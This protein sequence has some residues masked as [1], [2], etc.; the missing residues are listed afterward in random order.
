[1][2]TCGPPVIDM[3]AVFRFIHKQ[4]MNNGNKKWIGSCDD[5][6]ECGQIDLEQICDSFVS[7]WWR[8]TRPKHLE[9]KLLLIL[10]YISAE[11]Q[12]TLTKQR[13]SWPLWHQRWIPL[14]PR[15]A[16]HMHADWDTVGMQMKCC[17]V[18][19]PSPPSLCSLNTRVCVQDVHLPPATYKLFDAIPQEVVDSGEPI[20]AHG[21]QLKEW[22][23]HFVHFQMFVNN[24]SILTV[25]PKYTAILCYW[26]CAFSSCHVQVNL[27]HFNWKESCLL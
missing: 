12:F 23:V 18:H 17:V 15:N 4:Y 11:D 6:D 13:G 2:T 3:H 25:I 19:S 21:G 8:P 7:S 24:L 14:T 16:H 5:D 10:L 1:M 9:V 27:A 26:C 22:N 20:S